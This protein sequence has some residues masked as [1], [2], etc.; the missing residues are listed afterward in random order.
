MVLSALGWFG[1]L[2]LGLCAWAWVWKR[3]IGWLVYQILS[4]QNKLPTFK[5]K[6][7]PK[8]CISLANSAVNIPAPISI[9]YNE[10]HY[11]YFIITVNALYS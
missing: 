8:I 7:P 5:T 11:G 1:A 2:G 4:G 3:R 10:M 6:A 9:L